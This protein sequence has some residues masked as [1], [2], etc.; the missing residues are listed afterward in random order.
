MTIRANH[1][2]SAAVWSQ[3]IR[4]QMPV[5][6]QLN[7]PGVTAPSANHCKLR[8]IAFKAINVARESAR[9]I[10][11]RQIRVALRAVR[12]TG[13]RKANRSAMIRVAGSARRRKLLRRLMHGSVMTRKALLI[14]DIL[15]EKSRLC[16]MTS[17][18]LPA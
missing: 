2:H 5:V 7:G 16:H 9:T 10:S 18:A 3:Q 15:A 12:V 1:L 14:G 4:L 8:V 17:G 11:R 13:R 6:I